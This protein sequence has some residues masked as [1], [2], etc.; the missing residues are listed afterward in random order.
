MHQL[1]IAGSSCGCRQG[2]THTIGRIPRKVIGQWHNYTLWFD[3]FVIG[4]CKCALGSHHVE[5]KGYMHICTKINSKK[6]LISMK[7]LCIR[8]ASFI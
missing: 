1:L 6:I 5:V 4:D 8:Y 2:G 7:T 3:C